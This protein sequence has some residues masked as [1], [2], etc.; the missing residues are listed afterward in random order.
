MN[1]T[2]PLELILSGQ[3][4]LDFNWNRDTHA[5]SAIP[6]QIPPEPSAGLLSKITIDDE[7]LRDGLHGVSEYPRVE[8]MF[9]YVQ[10]ASQLGIKL[11]TVGIYSGTGVVDKT[12]KKL[13]I[14]M[15][16]KTPKIKPIILSLATAESINWAAACNRLN[17][18]LQVLIFMGSSPSRIMAESWTKDYVLDKLA[19]AI[20]TAKKKYKLKVIGATEHTTQTPPDFLREIIK[21]QVVNG[22]DYFCIADTIGSARPVGV[23]RIVKF[24]KRC[25]KEFGGENIAIDWHGHRDIGFSEVNVMT[26][27]SAG[28]SRVHL[29]PWGY[30]ERAGNSSLEV[31]LIKLLRAY[32][33]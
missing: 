8:E 20:K 17:P 22:I 12:I 3:M 4:P 29:V 19:W 15:A 24:V 16:K 11:M 33:R 6:K 32:A 13:L 5:N 2:N 9:K 23:Y 21:T 28:V 1:I 14:K 25:L 27:I 31:F 7:A 10:L 26:A 30:G 18:R